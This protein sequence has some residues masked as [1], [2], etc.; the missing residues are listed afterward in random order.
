MNILKVIL[1]LCFFFSVNATDIIS[2]EDY[3]DKG[4]EFYDD[5]EFNESFIVFLQNLKSL[6]AFKIGSCDG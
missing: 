5:G 6:G 4:V 1:F 2:D 3:Y